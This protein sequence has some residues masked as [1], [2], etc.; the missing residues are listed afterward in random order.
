MF[1]HVVSI[2]YLGDY[3]LRVEFNNGI[4]KDVDLSRE[5]FGEVFRPL[6]DTRFF[7]QAFVNWETGTV[8]WPNGADFAPEFLD[9]I[10]REVQRVA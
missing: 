6:Q 1:L 7:Q 10:G 4:I 2:R 5:L 3:Q 9:S 8:E